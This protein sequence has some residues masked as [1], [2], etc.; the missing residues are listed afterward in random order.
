MVLQADSQLEIFVMT[1][2][3][4]QWLR[5]S[6][7]RR[8]SGHSRKQRVWLQ[9][10]HLEERAVPT[11]TWTSLARP[12][13]GS[14]ALEMML[15][16][17]GTVMVHDGGG[18][19]SSVWER[20]T[21]DS[22]G[23]YI[24]GTWSRI[25][26]MHLARVAFASNVLTDGRVF[27]LGGE[28][29][30]PNSDLNLTNTGEIYDP[31]ANTWTTIPNFP[32][33]VYGDDPS[34][35]LPDGRVLAGYKLGPQ[36]YLYDPATNAWSAA[37]T[38]LHND[39]SREETWVK[40]P[41]NS[42]LSYDITSSIISGTGH[43]Q[44]YV[45]SL[46]QWVDAGTVP[47]LLSTADVAHEIG[48]AFLLPD[49]RVFF[50]G[51]TG[52]TAFYTPPTNPTDPGSWVDGPVIPNNQI[53][54]DAPGAMLPNGDVLFETFSPIDGST[55]VFEFNPT[56]NTYTDVTPP[57]DFP[58]NDGCLLVLPTGQVMA[59]NGTRQIDVFTPDGS[60]NPAWQPTISN[61]TDNGNNSFTL[62]GTQLNGLSEGSA[63]GDEFESASNYPIIRLTDVNGNVSFA[64]TFN[65]SSTGVATGSTPVSVEFTLPSIDAP[66]AYLVSVIANGIASAPVLDVQM[67]AVNT[68]LTLQVDPNDSASI[69]VLNSSSLLAEFPIS[70]F[71]SIIVT[72][73]NADNTVAIANTF[74]GVPVTVNEGSGHDTISLS[75]GDLD[76]I[77]GPLR[78]NGGSSASLVLNDQSF[79]LSRNF[80]VTGNT[81]TWGG[82]TVT[83]AGLGSVILDGGM[84][85]NT[86]DLLASSAATPVSIVGGGTQDTLVGSN[87]GNTFVITGSNSG[88]LSGTAYGSNVLFSQVGNL[89][90]GSGGDTFVFAD[91]ASLSGS[92]TGG[93]SDTLD[94]SAY[95][96][97]VLVDLQ[98]GFATG[99]GGPV[100]G[101]TTIFGGSAAP[102]TRGLYNL[103]IGK[104]GD[105]LYGGFGRPNI[106]V[107][108]TSASTLVGGGYSPSGAGSQDI[109]IAGS[110]A[111]DTEAGIT[112]WQQIAA[113]WAGPG[114]YTT[115]V[116]HLLSGNGV[117]LLDATVVMGNG[118][119]N[120]LIGYYS[121]LALLY[122]DGMDTIADFLA[123]SRQVTI[124]P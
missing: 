111:Y 17:D 36:T 29:S 56:T 93:G 65:W 39:P 119:G 43:A 85:G 32:K 38:K 58:P 98:T 114:A 34:E 100:N 59:T 104:G 54:D 71:S 61:I 89:T 26:P 73:S 75:N 92:I 97:S 37:G 55:D 64:R 82:P 44:R 45:P 18:A 72:G 99:V 25:A 95:R 8:S 35:V 107:A 4:L 115:K 12:F 31:V 5:G 60:P 41:D 11:G 33:P 15:L 20:L 88:T 63:F 28:Y 86:F 3:M 9:V 13:P 51:A 103:L 47:V 78:I 6:T 40:L 50:L 49:G 106:L 22:T 101:I 124:T 10:E 52:N 2:S 69:D 122:T 83:Y 66:G 94:Y 70:S 105:T 1:R 24:N 90:A 23:S 7:G 42:I 116:A 67:G 62:T 80:T 46:G 96:S 48:P 108:G 53:A 120:T 77:Q 117:P 109:L 19:A 87:A 110:T 81:I 118:G 21:P 113:Y 84:G 121:E 68:S 27:V 30:G 16:S 123:A 112:T 74:S 91:G 79:T 14:G 102:F 57:S 76:S